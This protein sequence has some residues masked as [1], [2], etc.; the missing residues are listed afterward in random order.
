M[1]M[2]AFI[3]NELCAKDV[4]AFQRAQHQMGGPSHKSNLSQF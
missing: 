3:E 4:Q 2:K 1:M